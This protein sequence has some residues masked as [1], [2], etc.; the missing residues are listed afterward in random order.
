MTLYNLH[1]LFC[2]PIREKLPQILSFDWLR[3]ESSKS[4][5]T[6]GTTDGRRIQFGVS[7]T[8]LFLSLGSWDCDI[9]GLY[10]RLYHG[11]V[12]WVGIST[13]PALSLRQYQVWYQAVSWVYIVGNVLGCMYLGLI[14]EQH[15]LFLS[16][17]QVIY[18]VYIYGCILVLYFGLA[19]VHQ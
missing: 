14:L 4:G 16:T 11:F 7:T 6:D 19:L 12:L 8:Q 18:W 10:F 17:V 13:T 3:V 1:S 2:Q 9:L 5:Q 15:K